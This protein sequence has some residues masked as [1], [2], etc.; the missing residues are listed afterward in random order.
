MQRRRPGTFSALAGAVLFAILLFLSPRAAAQEYYGV[1]IE[2][3]GVAFLLDVSGSMDN[4]AE[5]L[6]AA[7]E[8]ILRGFA[9]AF[10]DTA[11]GRSELGKKL[12]QR[13]AGT[14]APASKI[15][16]ARDE[17]M[18]ALDSLRDGTS[19]TI[20]TFGEG[21]IEWPEGVRPADARS[22]EAARDY[23]ARLEASGPTPMAEALQ[24]GFES[25]DVRTL[26]VVSDGRPTTAPVL[27][28]VKS[29][30]ESR[31]GRRL[32]IN[33]VG[34]G[35]D[36]DAE[37]LCQLALDNE[38]VYVRDGA[39]ACTFS[40]C[41]AGDGVVTFYPPSSKRK[42]PSETPVCSPAEHPDC[43]PELVYQTM[44]SE[45]RFQT[46]TRDRGEVTN[47][48]ELEQPDPVTIVVNP[49]GL[50]ATT[51][52]RP[53]H[54]F[55]PSRITRIVKQQDGDVVVE[56]TGAGKGGW[57]NIQSVDAALVDAV[58]GKLRPIEKPAAEEQPPAPPE[59]PDAP[60]K[61]DTPQKPDAPVLLPRSPHSPEP[62]PPPPPGSAADRQR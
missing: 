6:K 27:E 45:A 61:P 54:P 50:E 46:S 52:T 9:E 58:R 32:V 60:E 39:I 29:L 20:I 34:I 1:P 25:P 33:T 43:T 48:L 8:S 44:L 55:H 10:K 59:K 35:R 15:G 31:E 22:R 53:G 3:G 42:R 16:A 11:I 14:A 56:T 40:P 23:V 12:R 28:L 41:S 5:K 36:Q 57:N 49:E 13:P 30:Q 19:F 26:F 17:L 62:A 18:H 24:L 38:G 51:Y 37:L 2:D 47:C 4:K 7:A 21:A